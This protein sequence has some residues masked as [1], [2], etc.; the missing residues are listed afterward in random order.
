L[1]IRV[2]PAAGRSQYG[3]LPGNKLDTALD[4]NIVR[5]Y[6]IWTADTPFIDNITVIWR[7][8]QY[9][10]VFCP[11]ADNRQFG[12]P[13]AE[14]IYAY[15]PS[16]RSPFRRGTFRRRSWEAWTITAPALDVRT[17]EI[18]VFTSDPSQIVMLGAAISRNGR[19][20]ATHGPKDQEVRCLASFH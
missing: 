14:L 16:P 5:L 17:A 3:P 20:V 12:T 9:D 6:A 4:I 10:G 11:S 1:I 15:E 8:D 19:A 7:F 13:K 18:S 2:D